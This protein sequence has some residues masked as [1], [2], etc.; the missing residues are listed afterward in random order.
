MAIFYNP[1]KKKGLFYAPSGATG[2]TGVVLSISYSASAFCED[3]SDPTPTVTGNAGAGTFSSTTGLVFVST[4][5]GEVDID[6]S[7]S[8]A[9]YVITYT[10]TNAATATFNLTI[11]DLDD[12]TFAYSDSA[13]RQDAADPTPTIT[14]LAGG[15]FSGSTGLVI[16]STTGEIDLSASTEASH[17]ITYDTTLSGSSVCPNT[18]TQ[19]VQIITINVDFLVIAGGGSGGGDFGAGWG[20]GGGAGGYRNSYNNEPSGGGATS[21][22]SFIPTLATNYTVTVG[23]GGISNNNGANSIFANITSIGGGSGGDSPSSSPATGGSGG[24]AVSGNRTSFGSGTTGQGFNG[25][26]GGSGAGGGGGA[27]EAGDTDGI[28]SGGD[29]LQSSITG[30]AVYRGGGG[31]ADGGTAG[32]GGGGTGSTY[33]SVGTAGTGGGGGGRR[34]VTGYGSRGGSG[35]VILRYSNLFTITVGAGLT[36]TG[37]Q[38]DGNDKYIEFTAGTGNVSFS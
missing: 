4:T 15:T 14:G 37:E 7:T 3:A 31:S 26:A 19:S 9:T 21:E 32:A 18:S 29:G 16:N 35:I 34:A 33:P 17:T 27:A 22:N 24:G 6:A 30:T 23:E 8:G 25:G 36:T 11:N 38:T 5:T 1:N 10:D 20:G 12:A 13:Y 28:A 2:G